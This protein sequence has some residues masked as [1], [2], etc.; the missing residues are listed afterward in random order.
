MMNIGTRPTVDGKN[1]TIEVYFFDFEK[2]IY[3]ISI[4]VSILDRIRDEKKFDS[5][6]DLKKQIEKDKE[7]SISYIKSL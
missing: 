6:D 2:D 7:T 3:D 1:L 5:F 4:T